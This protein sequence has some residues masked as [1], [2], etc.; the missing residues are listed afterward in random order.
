MALSNSSARR[1]RPLGT[2]VLVRHRAPPMCACRGYCQRW[3]HLLHIGL[4]DLDAL[5]RAIVGRARTMHASCVLPTSCSSFAR[6]A[7]AGLLSSQRRKIDRVGAANHSAAGVPAR[8]RSLRGGA[9]K[10]NVGVARWHERTQAA[11]RGAGS[12]TSQPAP[13]VPDTSREGGMQG[14]LD[15]RGV[16]IGGVWFNESFYSKYSDASWI[17][18]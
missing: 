7:T 13:R 5:A 4:L 8:F 9:R 15:G 11:A 16:Y 17:N 12:T 6:S 2:V 18:S 14:V 3:L 10:G 1:G